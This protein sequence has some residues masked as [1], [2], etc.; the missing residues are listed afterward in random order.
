MLTAFAKNPANSRAAAN[1]DGWVFPQEIYQTFAEGKQHPVNVIVGSNADEGTALLGMMP[2]PKRDGFI[3]LSKRKY[4]DLTDRFLAAYPVESEADV[5]DAFL[6]SVRD[7]WFT[8]EMRTWARLMS[9]TPAKTYQYFF[10][11]VP[12]RPDA[13][14]YGA[15]HAAEVIYV[16]DNLDRASWF[17]PEV[18][19]KL[20]DTMAGAWVRFATTGDP[21]GE[22]LPKWPEF[23]QAGEPYL[24]FGDV[25]RPGKEL[26]KPQCD[27]YDAYVETLR[28]KA[29][30]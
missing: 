19:Q 29:Q 26:L 22:G 7:E 5:R 21:N 11:R 1:V 18:D 27:F 17:S 28:A 10:A 9:K 14:K 3:A 20:A 6:H 2:T 13:S 30:P 12:P 16:F 25:I 23:S 15:Y 8:W 4:G 24:E